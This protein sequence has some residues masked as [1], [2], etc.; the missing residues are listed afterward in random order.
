MIT[1]SAARAIVYKQINQ[2]DPYWLNK[3][4]LVATHAQEMATAWVIYYQSRAYLQSKSASDALVGNGPYVVCKTSGRFVIVSTAL[5]IEQGIQ[6]AV[7][8]LQ[9]E[10]V[11]E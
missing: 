8:Q 7:A 9:D 2:S 10:I 1:E 5:P 11:V 4:E 3:P 6:A